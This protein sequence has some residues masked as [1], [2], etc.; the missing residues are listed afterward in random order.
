M[1]LH[2]ASEAKQ[3]EGLVGQKAVVVTVVM[4]IPDMTCLLDSAEDVHGCDGFGKA[5]DAG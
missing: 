2:L 4:A 5:S 3:F 1:D